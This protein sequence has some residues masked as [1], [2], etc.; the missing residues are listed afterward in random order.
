M[1]NKFINAR[2]C[3]YNCNYHIAWTTK[4]LQKVVSPEIESRMREIILWTADNCGFVVHSI[5]IGGEGYV[6]LSVSAHPKM[7]VSYI[8]RALKSSTGQLLFKEFPS[9]K[10]KL[11]DGHLWDMSYFSETLGQASE[12]AFRAYIKEQNKELGDGRKHKKHK[13]SRKTEQGKN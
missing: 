13:A 12:I 6:R 10:S 8:V 11:Y 9:L 7:S 3:V 2:T 4:R 5:E 1:K